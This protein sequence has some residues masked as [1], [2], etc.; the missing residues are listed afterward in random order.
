MDAAV[1]LRAFPGEPLAGTV[2]SVSRQALDAKDDRLQAVTG[3]H[4]EVVVETGNPGLRVL[5]GMTGEMQVL[6]ERTTLAGAVARGVRGTFRSDL[7][8]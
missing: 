5:P 7:L 4:W 3:A 8:K 1:R 6:L 2:V